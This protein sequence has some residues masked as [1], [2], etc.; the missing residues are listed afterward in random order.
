VLD[1]TG[2]LPGRINAELVSFGPVDEVDGKRLLAIVQRH[3][4]LTGSPK[5]R[6]LLADWRA[7]LRRFVAVRP[8]GAKPAQSVDLSL[9]GVEEMSRAG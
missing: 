3:Y 7:A 2:V 4:E 8:T 9:Q 6:A 1:E 5:A